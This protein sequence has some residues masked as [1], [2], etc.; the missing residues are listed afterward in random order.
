MAESKKITYSQIAEPNLLEPLKKELEQVNA[1]LGITEENLKKVIIEAAKVAKQTPLDSFDNLEKIEKGINDTA[2][3]VKGLDKVE[4]DRA[5]L[6]ERIKELDDE[7]VKANFDLREQIRLQTKELRDNAKAAAT[8]GDAY[9]KLKRDTNKAQLEFKRL[10]SEFGANSK[11]AEEARKTFARFDDQLREVNEAAKDGR[12]D[13]GRYEEGTKK[14]NRAFK[15]FASA[16][17]I[18]KIFELLGTSISQNSDGAAELEKIWIRFTTIFAVTAKRIIAIFPAIQAS[19]QR[20][21]LASKIGLAEVKNLFGGN[22]EE[23]EALRKQYD[24]LADASVLNLSKAFSGMSEEIEGLI[25]KKIILID[26]TLA[27]RRQIVGLEQDVAALIPTQEKLRA[28][29]EDDSASLESQ[30][31]S[32]VAFREELSKRFR[33]EETIASKRL[34]LSQQNSKANLANVEAQEELSAATLEYNQ[35]IADQASEL[36]GTEREL[37]KLRDDAT[38]LNLDFYIDD[39]DNRKTVNERI[40]ADETQTFKHRK[41]LL[42]Q[43]QKGAETIFDLEEEAL[44][45]SLRER[46]K[47]QLDFDELRQNGSSEEIARIV[48]ESGISE[49]LAIRA[50]EV[51]RERRT[52]L[53]DNAEA[54]KDLNAAETES[55]LIQSDIV[56]QERALLR[57]QEQGADMDNVLLLLGE[58]R[59][60]NDIDNLRQRLT[61]AKE[62]SQEFIALNQQLNDKLLEQDQAGITKRKEALQEFGQAAN[63]TFQLLGDLSSNRSQKRLDSIDE[64]IQA[65]QKRVDSLRGLAEEGNEDA[66]NN[67]ALTEQR[68]AELEAKRQAQIK[69]QQKAELALAAIQAYSGKIAAGV[70][71]PLAATISDVSVLR[72]FIS[73]LPG[74]FDGTEDTGTV[75]NPLDSKG[76]RLAVIHDN[77]RII[78]AKKNKLIGNMSNAELTS[79][80]QREQ[81]RGYESGGSSAFLVRELREL[82]QITKDKPVYMGSDYDKI[83]NAVVDKIQKGGKIERIHRKNGGIWGQ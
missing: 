6:Q 60:Q 79:L 68:Q 65:E 45:R 59:L 20:F 21:V 63:E 41:A 31:K 57:L 73:S 8:T 71:N 42:E 83:A 82:K 26:D 50:L 18:L 67:I 80:A 7:R 25:A 29:F 69:R 2:E 39:F 24:D 77:E 54:Q 23:V 33:L 37:Q 81:R 64:E 19:F 38:Q 36:A 34:I 9:E 11:Q 58:E 17:I 74:F 35:L 78:D 32:G 16:T 30:I 44:N 46:G 56:L 4:K 75:A 13:V 12:R 14:L 55:R 53:Q 72:A 49:P 70:E 61:T 62:G 10:A 28:G 52:F 48:R 47:A 22:G 1:L 76:G 3:A 43:N 66:Q 27:Y 5:K 51:L 15:A 40:I